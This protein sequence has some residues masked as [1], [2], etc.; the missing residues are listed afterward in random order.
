MD[1]WRDS[2]ESSQDRPIPERD[3]DTKEGKDF[4]FVDRSW[5]QLGTCYREWP[6]EW[7]L[8][9]RYVAVETLPEWHVTKLSLVWLR[10]IGRDLL[11]NV[12]AEMKG[13]HGEEDLDTHGIK[14]S[15]Q[16]LTSFDRTHAGP[17][18]WGIRSIDIT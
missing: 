9:V 3:E 16:S 18:A 8:S 10:S 12:T 15:F 17:C 7:V 13:A 2:L 14:V 1:T 5:H 6:G 4:A 11:R